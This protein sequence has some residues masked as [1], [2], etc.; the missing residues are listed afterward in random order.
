MNILAVPTTK[1]VRSA[2]GGDHLTS[3]LDEVSLEERITLLLIRDLVRI[4]WRLKSNTSNSFEFAP[5]NSYEK[6]VVKEAMAYAR[7]AILDRDAR[8]IEK[9]LDLAWSNLAEG[10]DVLKSEICP[11]IEVCRTQRQ[12]D[13]FRILRYYW[14][15]PASE[16]V[17]R[18]IRLLVRDDGIE[19]S[20]VIGIAALGSSIIHI[21]DRDRWIGW[22]VKT[23]TERIVYMMDAYVL[24]ALPPYNHLL[25]GKLISYILASNEIRDIY[26]NKYSSRRTIIKNRVASDLVLIIT[27]SLYGRN[28]SQYNRLRYGKSLLYKPIGTTSGFGSLHISNETF[29]TMLE[30]AKRNGCNVSNRFGEG[31]NWRMRVIRAACD[32]LDL[33]S[34]VILRHSFRRGLFVTPLAKNWKAFLNGKTDTPV[35]RNLPMRKLV[36]YWRER[37]LHMRKQNHHV[38]S[39]VKFFSPEQFNI[40]RTR[41]PDLNFTSCSVI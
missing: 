23:R 37:W 20:P 13:I 41:I 27:T 35:Y 28:S 19:G 38:T 30:L 36:E 4:G 12:H 16:Y 22:D 24:G 18:R 40:R 6:P 8:W 11:R 33:D 7:N 14:S 1:K 34:E 26:R 15:S 3:P 9:H 32:V 25:G 31:P 10:E 5:P 2:V 39:R 17:G 29:Y 21:S